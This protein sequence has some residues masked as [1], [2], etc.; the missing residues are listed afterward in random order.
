MVRVETG[1]SDDTH[2][3]ITSGL[4]G[5]EKAIIGPYRVVSRTLTPDDPVTEKSSGPGK[6]GP[7]EDN[8]A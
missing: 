3:Q 1:I 4:D 6:A 2:I 5:G 8:D 7:S